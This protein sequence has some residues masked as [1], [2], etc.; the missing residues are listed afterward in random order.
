MRR[1]KINIRLDPTV[2]AFASTRNSYRPIDIDASLRRL[3]H[4]YAY[5]AG[6]ESWDKDGSV[7]PEPR[8]GIGIAKVRH[9][10]EAG[11]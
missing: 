4:S 11:P 3:L 9:K 8:G 1:H 2:P 10:A 6:S 7:Y 5:K